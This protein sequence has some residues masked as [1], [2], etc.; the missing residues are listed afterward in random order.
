LEALYSNLKAAVAA[1][2]SIEDLTWVQ[3]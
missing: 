1:A 2:T 3:L